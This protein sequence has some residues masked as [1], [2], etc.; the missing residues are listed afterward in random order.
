MP[1]KTVP[2]GCGSA[3]GICEASM[4]TTYLSFRWRPPPG[5]ILTN[6]LCS[7]PRC[8]FSPHNVF[9]LIHN[10]T[11]R[12]SPLLAHTVVQTKLY[13][14]CICASWS[15]EIAYHWKFARYA[16]GTTVGGLSALGKGLWYVESIIRP[17]SL[18]FW[19]RCFFERFLILSLQI[20]RL[21][22]S[23]Y[24]EHRSLV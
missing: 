1:V 10:L 21:S 6:G 20:L 19:V 13:W 12:A 24:Q 2:R 14:T 8:V 11:Y 23:K 5:K 4:I 3:F 15:K 18:S 17:S 9:R 16:E 7:Y 22:M